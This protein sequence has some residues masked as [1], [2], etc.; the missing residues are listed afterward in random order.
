MEVQGI[1]IN[2]ALQPGWMKA[3][4]SSYNNP[5]YFNC[6]IT[7]HDNVES[8]EMDMNGRLHPQYDK[9]NISGD[10]TKNYMSTANWGKL[11]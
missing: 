6:N 3:S 4:H 8:L 7:K 10:F 2:T 5:I 1:I 11:R 9:R